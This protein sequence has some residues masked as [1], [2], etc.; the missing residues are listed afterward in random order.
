MVFMLIMT[1]GALLLVI[2]RYKLSLVG[3][4]GFV[5]LFLA[6]LLILEAIDIFEVC[7]SR[8]KVY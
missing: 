2:I 1:L 8:S 4:I 6:L 7:G 5:L 3:C